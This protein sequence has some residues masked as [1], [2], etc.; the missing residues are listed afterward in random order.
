MTE[1][2]KVKESDVPSE[3]KAGLKEL[4]GIVPLVINGKKGIEIIFRKKGD[5]ITLTGK[6][7]KLLIDYK[8][9]NDAFRG[10][11]L[12]NARSDKELKNIKLSEKRRME[13]TF[14]MP[15]ASR[16]AV[17]NEKS[18][19][20]WF[21][22]MALAGINGF[23]FYTEET[24]EVPGEK[25]FGYMRGK[26]TIKEL[27]EYDDYAA[28]FGIEMIP[29]IQALAHMQR[30]L[31]YDCYNKIK[32][33]TSVMLCESEETLKFIEKIIAA[34]VKPF[35]SKRI[36]IGMDEAWD[37]GRGT[38]LTKHG[39]VP[40]FEIM[41]KH[42][43][44][45]MAII[46]KLGLRP[47]MWS[48]MFFRA[49]SATHGYYDTSITITKE[50]KKQIPQDVDLVYWDYYHTKTSDYNDMIDK[51]LEMG[52]TPIM[53]PGLQSWN[54]FWAGYQYAE[55]TV[56]A[57]LKSCFGKGV[58]ELVLTIWGDDG[59]ECDLFSTFPLLQFTSDM[60]F[61][62]K[63]DPEYSK[64]NLKGSAGIDYDDWKIAGT[65]DNAPFI[66]NKNQ[67]TLAKSLFW[68]DPL[69][70]LWQPQ[71]DGNRVNSHFKK[72]STDL[73]KVLAKKG[74][75][76]LMMPYLL[77]DILADKA[78]LPT[79]IHEAYHKNDKKKLKEIASKTI[80]MLVEKIRELNVCHRGVWLDNNKPFGWEVLERRYGGLIN[81][82]EYAKFRL[83]S[84]LS[85]DIFKVEE[86]EEK[87]EKMVDLP[88]NVFGGTNSWRVSSTG[89]Y[90]HQML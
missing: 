38:Y 46:R 52:S 39:N 1:R 43:N 62:G 2:F 57:G 29:C 81:V 65:M 54:R 74:N 27:K 40:P 73:K 85:G 68:E 88:R 31:Q 61:T 49:L 64:I 77:T 17:L 42:L 35:R 84:Y 50:M 75:E 55:D 14:V 19:C 5:G 13:K 24:Y 41:T 32:D 11:G 23:M 44:S 4:A 69:L 48:D 34:A 33:T 87:K 56:S 83:D 21:R 36:H 9:I 76:R 28:K 3:L 18:V 86:L 59:T 30:I 22:F 25:M 6:D 78:D 79:I 15:D 37:L 53:A 58:K 16:N 89:Q 7:G 20:E 90:F 8:E 51:H 63:A 71:L 67:P 82:M 26:L 47:M 80:P 10:L 72:V 12:A 60:V 66:K 45:V 70:G